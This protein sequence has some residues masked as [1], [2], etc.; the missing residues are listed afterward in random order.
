MGEEKLLMRFGGKTPI[1][2]CAE[3][4]SKCQTEFSQ[5]IVAVSDS[6]RAEAKSAFL[7]AVIVDGGA[8]RGLSV[9]YALDAVADADIVV[10]H[11]AARCMVT[12]AIIDQSVQSAMLYGCGVA[13]VMARDTIWYEGKTI[14]RNKVMLAQTPQTFSFARI[15][16]A[17]KNGESY[18]DDC[19]LYQAAGYTPYFSE[20]SLQNQKLTYPQDIPFFETV[21]GE[22]T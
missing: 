5:K 7:D 14:E 17:Y 19:S 21:L 4:I 20:G 6:T 10:I 22:R 1:A 18:T 16:K 11:D 2:Y 3:A 12:S 8:T 15:K 13:A 9:K